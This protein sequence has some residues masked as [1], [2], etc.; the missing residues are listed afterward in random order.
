[1]LNPKVVLYPLFKE[2]AKI[3]LNVRQIEM[4]MQQTIQIYN[5]LKCN[6]N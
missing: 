4:R 2:I 1:M 3:Y 5:S 6:S